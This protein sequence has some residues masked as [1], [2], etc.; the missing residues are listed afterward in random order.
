MKH[1]AWML[2]LLFLLPGQVNAQHGYSPDWREPVNI[3]GGGTRL[4]LSVGDNIAATSDGAIYIAYIHTGE[5]RLIRSTDDGV[6]WEVAGQVP[7][8]QSGL[9]TLAADTSD[10]L[11][12]V[13]ANRDGL[14]EYA[15]T[16]D[17]GTTWTDV[18]EL[19]TSDEGEATSPQV[20]V[21]RQGRVHVA[22]HNGDHRNPSGPFAEVF[23][24][25]SPDGGDTW[26]DLIPLST[27]DEQH[28][29]FPRFNFGSATGDDL[30]IPWR[31][32]RSDGD[33]DVYAAV[34]SDGGASWE[35]V[36][37][38]GGS[39][40]QW[41]PVSLVDPNGV[42]HL[43][44]M[45]YPLGVNGGGTVEVDYLRSTDFETWTEPQAVNPIRSRF[46][47]LLY[48]YEAD[49]LWFLTKDERD[50][51]NPRTVHADVI[52]LYSSDS[53]LTW[54]EPEFAT[55]LGDA[56]MGLQG[57]A[58]GPDGRVHINFLTLA[59]TEEETD[60]LFFVNRHRPSEGA[61]IPAP[62]EDMGMGDVFDSDPD[63]ASDDAS[64]HDDASQT[65]LTGSGDS[66]GET[67]EV[68]AFA[69]DMGQDLTTTPPD[70]T[71]DSGCTQ[72]G[73]SLPLGF[74]SVLLFLLI[75]ALAPLRSRSGRTSAHK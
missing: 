24:R 3:A 6:T 67:N 42:A 50:Y 16:D 20:S 31:D 56:E 45:Y 27:D 4:G 65:D 18:V 55:D 5:H 57:Y 7:A 52:S 36:L 12:M 60:E 11:H 48:D 74:S 30:I 35:E 26:D 38:A 43:G 37:A 32:E 62:A 64:D 71:R 61:G 15:R 17:G 66:E 68:D 44:I 51:E 21:D 41:D 23:Y 9:G 63:L 49:I 10:R 1:C 25:R 34:S 53:G 28:S 8:E 19:S 39:G 59:Q 40:D 33:W 29:A 70:S 47:H 69:V 73:N 54:S 58:V 14:V 46:P 2:V 72:P 13:W 75:S 22:W